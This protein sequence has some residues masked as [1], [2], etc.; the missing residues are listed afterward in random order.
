M[1]RALIAFRDK[2]LLFIVIA[3]LIGFIQA[4]PCI[5]RS[6]IEY[7]VCDSFFN[8]TASDLVFKSFSVWFILKIGQGLGNF[9]HNCEE[10]LQEKKVKGRNLLKEETNAVLLNHIEADELGL[11]EPDE[12]YFRYL[13]NSSSDKSGLDSPKFPRFFDID[14]VL[15]KLSL[16]VNDVVGFNS[17]GNPFPPAKALAEGLEISEEEFKRRVKE[18]RSKRVHKTAEAFARGIRESKD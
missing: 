3:L 1:K 7:G 9:I 6:D 12:T 14:D 18:E 15:V 17:F 11:R 13:Q 16:E 8:G 4:N 10:E 5:V 2:E